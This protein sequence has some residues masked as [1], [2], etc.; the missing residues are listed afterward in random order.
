[1]FDSSTLVS[2]RPHSSLLSS[3]S[4]LL[5][6]LFAFQYKEAFPVDGWKVY[7]PLAEYKRQVAAAAL[8]HVQQRRQLSDWNEIA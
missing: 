3:S 7:D 2:T 5:Q 6:P 8:A 1:M 4:L